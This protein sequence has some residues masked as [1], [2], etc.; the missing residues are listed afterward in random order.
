MLTEP[1]ILEIKGLNKNFNGLKAIFDVSFDVER[2]EI[3]SIIGPNGAGKT[4]LFNLI[5]G[6]FPPSSGKIIFNGKDITHLKSH[7]IASLGI[8]RTFQTQSLFNSLTTGENVLIGCKNSGGVLFFKAGLRLKKCKK[9]EFQ[10]LERAKEVLCMCGLER[11]ISWPIGSLS[12]RERKVLEIM[13]AIA[14]EPSLLLLD[15]P[16]AGLRGREIDELMDLILQIKREGVTIIMVEHQMDVVMRMSNRIVVL[17]YGVKISEGSPQEVSQDPAV[18]QA[19][20]GGD[21]AAIT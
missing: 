16:A 6:V 12:L 9:D 20:L 4:T 7:Q 19:Y 21:F 8:S 2:E 18:I 11:K 10:S 15:E 17:N 5:T 3:L 1:K 13:R 14:S